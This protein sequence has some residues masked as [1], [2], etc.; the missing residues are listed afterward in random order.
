MQ[1]KFSPVHAKKAKEI[2]SETVALCESISG[3]CCQF[4]IY[5]G[6]SD[7]PSEHGLSH[8]VV[9]DLMS[10]YLDKGYRLYF[11]NLYTSFRLIKDLLVQNTFSCGTIRINRGE[12][13][14]HLKTAVLKPGKAIYIKSRDIVAVHWKDKR[15]VL[16]Y[17]LF[18]AIWRRQL[19]DTKEIFKNLT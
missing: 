15:D 13:P 18:M 2:W 1:I 12:F 9:F 3:Y 16:Q 7:G 19:S 5:T 17:P 11:D 6:K 8:R 4:Q 10:Q 14:E